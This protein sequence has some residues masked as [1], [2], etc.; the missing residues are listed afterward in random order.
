M[1]LI[2]SCLYRMGYPL[3]VV[4]GTKC[5]EQPPRLE[6]FKDGNCLLLDTNAVLNEIKQYSQAKEVYQ[7]S[8][9]E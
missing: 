1:K 7:K 9:L 3:I 2:I 8:A 5:M 6:L 4:V